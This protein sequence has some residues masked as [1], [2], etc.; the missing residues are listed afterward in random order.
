MGSAVDPSKPFRVTLAW[1]DA[2]GPV[3]GAAFVNNLDLEVFVNGTRY[4]GNRFSGA[5]S[6]PGGPPDFANNLEGVFLPSGTGSSFSVT[7]RAANV[8][9]NGVPG[10]GDTT[11]QDF[12]LVIYNAAARPVLRAWQDSTSFG[13]ENSRLLLHSSQSANWD[14]DYLLFKD[15]NTQW[16]P[17]ASGK[18]RLRTQP[19]PDGADDF[20]IIAGADDE[21]AYILLAA[22]HGKLTY[23]T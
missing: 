16:G 9:G 5:F 20:D 7:V 6:T 8:P 22:V 21:L 12:A 10:V 2:P 18:L 14:W 23:Y 19:G 11:D 4:Q 3:V 1:S 17:L 15:T 13:L